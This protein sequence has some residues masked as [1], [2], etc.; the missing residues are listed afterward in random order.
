MM[1]KAGLLLLGSSRSLYLEGTW[2][3][4]QFRS[5][6][7]NCIQFRSKQ[8]RWLGMMP[9]ERA[10]HV[11]VCLCCGETAWRQGLWEA[12]L[13]CVCQAC[14]AFSKT[15]LCLFSPDLASLCITAFINFLNYIGKEPV[16]VSQPT[17]PA[18]GRQRQEDQSSQSVWVTW[19]CRRGDK[20]KHPE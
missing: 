16:T 15:D 13:T 9:G 18:F 2:S 8:L 17:I 10:A 14:R 5:M 6:K 4:L 3:H 19:V 1:T 11:N 7:T 20:F 12:S